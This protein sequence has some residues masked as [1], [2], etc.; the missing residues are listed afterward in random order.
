MTVKSYIL[1]LIKNAW[2]RL[3]DFMH[4]QQEISKYDQK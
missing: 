4:I 3:A 2:I 1:I